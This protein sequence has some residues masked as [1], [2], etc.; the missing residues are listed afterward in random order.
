MVMNR[1]LQNAAYNAYL[2][3]IL[4]KETGY[5]RDEIAATGGAVVTSNDRGILGVLLD[6]KIAP[7]ILGEEVFAPHSALAISHLEEQLGK[8]AS[9]S[10]TYWKT[11]TIKDDPSYVFMSIACAYR[12]WQ[13]MQLNLKPAL[14]AGL[15]DEAKLPVW[16]HVEVEGK[17]LGHVH[18]N[19][20]YSMPYVNEGD[21]HSYTEVEQMAHEVQ[22]LSKPVI[23]DHKRAHKRWL[24][25]PLSMEEDLSRLGLMGVPLHVSD[26]NRW[27]I[28]KD[29][30]LMLR[31][32]VHGSKPLF[33]IV[34]PNAPEDVKTL[35]ESAYKA[36]PIT[37]RTDIDLTTGFREKPITG[38]KTPEAA[39]I[40]GDLFHEA[41][42]AN[43]CRARVLT[44]KG[45]KKFIGA[46][47][48]PRVVDLLI[49]KGIPIAPIAINTPNMS[50]EHQANSTLFGFVRDIE[51]HKAISRIIESP[52][53]CDLLQQELHG[54][55]QALANRPSRRN[56]LPVFNVMNPSAEY[57]GA[58][59]CSPEVFDAARTLE[60][61]LYSLG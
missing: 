27:G 45:N 8:P 52:E 36:P 58:L 41:V 33:L 6:V 19:H 28:P 38:L 15:A 21:L 34:D 4:L 3:N 23:V 25:C 51:T 30:N 9:A 16:P 61:S 43:Q 55:F 53:Q 24:I 26:L 32:S 17:S 47:G 44:S 1:C 54:L 42:C 2:S 31:A 40:I 48:N 11:I 29:P 10:N 57:S 12:K 49:N 13:R 46:I 20:R 60:R 59:V 39:I 14:M 18:V 37:C 35:I 22:A 50:L 5:A 56:I 7:A